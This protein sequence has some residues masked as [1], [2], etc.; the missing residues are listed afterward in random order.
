MT[1]PRELSKSKLEKM[2]KVCAP[3]LDRRPA[4][5]R[6]VWSLNGKCCHMPKGDRTIEVGHLIKA[7]S[8]L[9]I[10]KRCAREHFPDVTF[11]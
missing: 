7:V 11:R 3:D 4:K 8:Q 2:L 10:D 9:G 5:R 6:E 1:A